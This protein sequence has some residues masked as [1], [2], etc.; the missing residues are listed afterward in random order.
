M[1]TIL[2]SE[3]IGGCHFWTSLR[4]P[5]ENLCQARL[6]ENDA[7]YFSEASSLDHRCHTATETSR[8]HCRLTLWQA[9]CRWHTA[10]FIL[11]VC[12]HCHKH[13]P[14]AHH[15]TYAGTGILRKL[16]CIDLDFQS[17]DGHFIPPKFYDL[18]LCINY[19]KEAWAECKVRL[20]P[21][22]MRIQWG[23]LQYIS[24]SL[25]TMHGKH[26][27]F[28]CRNKQ[29]TNW[30]KLSHFYEGPMTYNWCS[31]IG[32]TLCLRP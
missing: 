23:Y 27:D 29:W 4:I 12:I 1:C 11:Q 17:S 18:I 24:Q 22:L 9:S 30:D 10:T 8:R 14:C 21:S 5:S 25:P 32:Q 26:C 6:C 31:H 13:L 15:C 7:L 28:L 19:T 16:C 20:Q 3:P 2:T